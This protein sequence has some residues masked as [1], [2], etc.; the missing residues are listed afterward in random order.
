MHRL[1]LFLT[2]KRDGR[3]I[4][5]TAV[6]LIITWLF[7]STRLPAQ[8][9][10]PN[11]S[12]EALDGIPDMWMLNDTHFH[13]F[14]KDW[15]SPT[16]GSPDIFHNR[17]KDRFRAN[18]PNVDMF[19][20]RPRSG[21]VMTGI[22][23][24]GCRNGTLH[25]KEY[26]QVALTQPLVPGREYSVS[27]WVNPVETSVRI[28]N[29]GAALSTRQERFVTVLNLKGIQP[30]VYSDT[31]IYGGRPQ[32]WSRVAGSFIADSA[33]THLIIG[34]FFSDEET[35]AEPVSGGL[36]YAYYLIDD[37]LLRPL[38][39]GEFPSDDWPPIPMDTAFELRTVLFA[40]D[41]S[42]L[43]PEALPDL[44]RLA[45]FLKFRP[46]LEIAIS[47]HTDPVGGA[48]YN[49]RL[50][51]ARAKAVADY[52]IE[53]GA[54]SSQVRW[55]GLGATQPRGENDTEEGR[56]LNR[57]VEVIVRERR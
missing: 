14:M 11:F 51:E 25:C 57:R 46:D 6:I 33:Y 20:F 26:L 40:F 19:P 9:L 41:R 32:D 52:L 42:N 45:D 36:R 12:F 10:V 24:F 48:E 16:E 23:G 31:V 3:H 39:P 18:R 15:N 21:Y 28:N 7:F 13:N 27:Y 2:T 5:C 22:K 17:A 47:G 49:Q 1:S 35:I 53:K 55:E 38:K 34:N 50:S 43:N 56:R 29:W 30:K 54:G 37:V 8:N 4:R 44:D